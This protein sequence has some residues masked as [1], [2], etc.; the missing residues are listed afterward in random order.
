MYVILRTVNQRRLVW[1][2]YTQKGREAEKHWQRKRDMASM[3]QIERERE[4]GRGREKQ[5]ERCSTSQY[6]KRC[7]WF[8]FPPVVESGSW[9]GTQQW[10]VKCWLPVSVRI[11]PFPARCDVKSAANSSLRREGRSGR[12]PRA[13]LRRQHSGLSATPTLGFV[14]DANTRACLRR[15]HSGLTWILVPSAGGRGGKV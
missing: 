4:G 5:R 7:L 6:L 10:C 1:K 14:C 12:V 8:F 13:C 3:R 15:Q 2:A 11:D 9:L